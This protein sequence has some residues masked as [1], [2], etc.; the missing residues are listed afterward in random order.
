MGFTVWPVF[1]DGHEDSLGDEGKSLLRAHEELD[2]IAKAAGRTPLSAFDAH[3]DVPDEVVKR[4][5]EEAQD[6]PDLS[7]FPVVWHAPA[8]AVATLDVLLSAVASP[9]LETV[10]GEDAEELAE[11]L[12]AFRETLQEAAARQTW[13][14]FIIA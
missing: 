2:A 6:L 12:E 11:C 9:E 10:G 3:S 7:G 14:H 4:M 8:D 5:A 13:F 1:E